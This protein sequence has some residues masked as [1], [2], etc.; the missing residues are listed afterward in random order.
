VKFFAGVIAAFLVIVPVSS[1]LEPGPWKINLTATPLESSFGAKTYA[2]WN[3]PTYPDRI[4]TAFVHCE[5]VAEKFVECFETLRLG[6]GQISAHAVVP[7]TSTFKLLGVTGGTGLYANTGGQMTVQ[8]LGT[9]Q[10]ILVDLLAF[11]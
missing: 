10:L 4:G 1:G 7:A 9:G 11:G 6:R 5:P 8:Q 3:R 2:L